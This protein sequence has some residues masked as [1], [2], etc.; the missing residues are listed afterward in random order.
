MNGI[1]EGVV[2]EEYLKV[3]FLAA[4]GFIAQRTAL[5]F[6]NGTSGKSIF[7][8][9]M[10]YVVY[11]LICIPLSFLVINVL[12]IYPNIC[13]NSVISEIFR[14]NPTLR[15]LIYTAICIAIISSLFGFLWQ[16]VFKRGLKSLI[17]EISLKCQNFIPVAED[18][19]LEDYFKNI[20]KP[21]L[22][23]IKKDDR[24]IMMGAYLG[25][26]FNESVPAINVD[27]RFAQIEEWKK[28]GQELKVN[29]RLYIPQYDL[30]IEVYITPD[31]F[32]GD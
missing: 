18:M 12:N 15:Q 14:L 32:F 10:T 17:G 9:V 3:I 21:A 27:E 28:D 30:V 1:K 22:I 24:Q 16:I 2:V 6:G 8:S 4:P 11:S 13:L 19:F 7:D 31:H 25:S 23:A 20:E 29:N 26:S 5:W